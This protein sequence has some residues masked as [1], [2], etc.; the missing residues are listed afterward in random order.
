MG[1]GTTAEWTSKLISSIDGII[2]G[3]PSFRAYLAPGDKHCIIPYDELY[4]V[5]VDGTLLVDWLAD[6]V[7]GK[8]VKTLRCKTCLPGS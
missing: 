4:T 2:K 1:G 3:A 6:M 8:P 7:A 5:S